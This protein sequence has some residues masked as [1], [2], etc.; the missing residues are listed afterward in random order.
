LNSTMFRAGG[1]HPKFVPFIR[2]KAIWSDKERECE[3]IAS[4]RSRFYSFQVGFGRRRASVFKKLF[5]NANLPTLYRSRRSLTR[6]LGMKLS[7]DELQSSGLWYRE[8]FYLEQ[9]EEP[10]LPFGTFAQYRTND[11]PKG[12]SRVSPHWYPESMVLGW[13]HRFSFETV[14]NAWTE[15]VI[16]D[17]LA[18]KRWMDECD[19]GCSTW[20]LSSFVNPLMRRLTKLSRKGLWRWVC[21]RRN[22]S[23]FGRVRF[24]RGKGCVKKD[25]VV[26]DDS[27]V[28]EYTTPPLP[29][30]AFR[31]FETCSSPVPR[32]AARFPELRRRALGSAAY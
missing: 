30:S 14:R 1:Q 21:L 31:P 11:V 7:R 12:W 15:P 17:S 10:P 23:V 26:D 16:N 22:E 3:R 18:E 25:A 5:L 29:K 19:R 24:E 4:L 2:P 8:L 9:V 32:P 28:Q 20:G 6:G 27:V 13:A